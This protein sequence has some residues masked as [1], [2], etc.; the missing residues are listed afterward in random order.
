MIEMRGRIKNGEKIYKD[1]LNRIFFLHCYEAIEN[2]SFS[3][4]IT[5]NSVLFIDLLRYHDTVRMNVKETYQNSGDF[6]LPI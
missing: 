5:E 3:S 1:P 2:H 6:I 4:N